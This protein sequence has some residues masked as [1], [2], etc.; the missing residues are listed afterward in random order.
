MN[1][2]WCSKPCAYQSEGICTLE[3]LIVPTASTAKQGCCY[4]VPSKPQHSQIQ[5]DHV[6]NQ[7]RQH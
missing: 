1:L 6:I 5:P 2:I 4:F 3:Q 7:K